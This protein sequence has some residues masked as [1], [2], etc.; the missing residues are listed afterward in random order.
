MNNDHSLVLG[1]LS[2]HYIN[3]HVLNYLI[4]VQVLLTLSLLAYYAI[5]T[6]FRIAT[7]TFMTLSTNVQEL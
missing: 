2:L 3:G 4:Y 6:I 1:L 7:Y 5:I